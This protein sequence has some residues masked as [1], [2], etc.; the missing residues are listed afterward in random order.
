MLHHTVKKRNVVFD[1][2]LNIL[3]DGL[4]N[5]LY[6]AFATTANPGDEKGFLIAALR[7]FFPSLRF[8][9]NKQ[10]VTFALA[11]ETMSRIGERLL[12]EYKASM[13]KST[14]P[15][16]HNLVS[17]LAQSNTIEDVSGHP[18]MTDE[19]IL[20]QVH[21]FFCAGYLTTSLTVTWALYELTQNKMVQNKLREELLAV[22]TDNPTMDQL[23]SLP[24]LDMFIRET[25]RLHAPLETT[26]RAAVEDVVLPLNHPVTDQKGVSHHILRLRKGQMVF[27]PILVMN[28]QKSIWG[29]DA[30]E[31]RPERWKTIPSAAR[32]VPGVWGNMMTF[33]DGPR[34]C[35]GFRFSLVEMRALLFTLVRAF[36]FELA[37]RP[38]GITVKSSFIHRPICLNGLGGQD[39]MPLLIKPV[40]NN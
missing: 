34:A 38:E 39:Q 5:E 26:V 12:R 16:P 1:C 28:R 35:P 9:E 4:Q 18:R 40:L 2:S 15:V 14:S 10:D 27:I 31:F 33:F 3:D 36:E 24:Y 13:H 23:N 7:C 17:L 25:L 37:V 6:T 21:T 8:L 22:D 32:E 30:L 20:A 29:D 11:R 19:D